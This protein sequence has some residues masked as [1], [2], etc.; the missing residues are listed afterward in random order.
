MRGD[1][2]CEP[3]AREASLWGLA[4]LCRRFKGRLIGALLALFA[5]SALNLAF[6]EVVRRALDP[7]SAIYAVSQPVWAGTVL[8]TLFFFQ[9]SCYFARTYLFGSLAQRVVFDVR[10]RLYASLVH[11]PVPF[12]ESSRTGDLASRLSSDTLLL[13]DA[14]AIRASVLVRYTVQACCGVALMA[15]I[16]LRLTG[17]ILLLLPLIIGSSVI[18]GGKLKRLTRA[19]QAALGS[20]NMIAEE[21]LGNVRIVKAYNAEEAQIR[22]YEA[23]NAAI[24]GVGMDRVQVSALFQSSITFLLNAGLTLLGLYAITLVR[25]GVL[26]VGDLA[27]FAL[28]GAIVAT[29]FSFIASSYS[30]LVQALGAVERVQEYLAETPLAR[31]I[32][33]EPTTGGSIEFRDVS[34]RFPNRPEVAVLNGLTFS[35]PAGKTTAIVG[36]SGAGK[37]AVVSLILRFYDPQHGTITM[38]GEDLHSIDPAVIRSR[39]AL[40]PQDPILFATSLRENLLL[41]APDA[42][43]R[44]LEEVCRAVNIWDFVLTLPN[45][46][47][48]NVGERGVQL[49]GGQRQRIAIARALLRNPSLLILDEATSALDSTNEA[50]IHHELESLMLGRTVVI[51]AHRFSSIAR[52][53]RVVVIHSGRVVQ[54]GTHDTLRSEEGLYRELASHQYLS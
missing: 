24:L 12:F 14:L 38:D 15:G 36:P 51:I 21:T 11:Q 44:D 33:V 7:S 20:A 1:N 22:R 54:E 18:L 47:E 2:T 23:A 8:L 49:S 35:I 9:S 52:A 32:E 53:D 41:G 42:T 30:E 13:Q 3:P 43:D 25:D 4:L 37:S 5:G 48:T 16:S 10:Q 34:F 45:K 19:Q 17:L 31:P 39:I 6:P 50:T 29:S 46:L 40:V 28:Y 27:A 26:P